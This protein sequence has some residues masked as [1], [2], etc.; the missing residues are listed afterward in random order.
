LS[1]Q[2]HTRISD[3]LKAISDWYLE[4]ARHNEKHCIALHPTLTPQTL[5]IAVIT[6]PP[7]EL[8]NHFKAL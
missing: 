4:C 3:G 2:I 1:T 8:Q 7:K 5:N 6:E